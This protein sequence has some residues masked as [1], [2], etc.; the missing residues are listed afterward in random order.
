MMTR[1]W[2]SAIKLLTGRSLFWVIVIRGDGPRRP[3]RPPTWA[4]SL[5]E[6]RLLI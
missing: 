1:L 3:K 2:D 5:Q 4:E 6:L